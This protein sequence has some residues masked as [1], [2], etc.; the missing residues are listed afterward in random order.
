MNLYYEGFQNSQIN[1]SVKNNRQ[2]LSGN[3]IFSFIDII[4]NLF[5][6][7]NFNHFQTSPNFPKLDTPMMKYIDIK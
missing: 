7:W 4:C 2:S 6:S 1:M 5:V 3:N